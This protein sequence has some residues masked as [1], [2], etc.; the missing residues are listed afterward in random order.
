MPNISKSS[1]PII[2]SRQAGTVLAV[3]LI[4]LTMLSLLVASTQRMTSFAA[5]AAGWTG[6]TARDFT[7]V[8]QTLKTALTRSHWPRVATLATAPAPDRGTLEVSFVPLGSTPQ[9]PHRT[10]DPNLHRGLCA[11]YYRVLVVLER[12]GVTRARHAA[13]VALAA[14]ASAVGQLPLDPSAME[15]PVAGSLIRVGWREHAL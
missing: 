15:L 5:A 4:L 14:P 11:H 9:L 13:L 2:V 10:Y 6:A 3:S 12:E 1:T 8:E 7:L